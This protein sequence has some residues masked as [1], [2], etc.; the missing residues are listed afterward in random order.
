MAMEMVPSQV[1]GMHLLAKHSIF[2]TMFAGLALQQMEL[3]SLLMPLVADS[4]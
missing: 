2:G 3:D 4:E 1:Y